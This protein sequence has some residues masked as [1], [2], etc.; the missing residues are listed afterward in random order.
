MFFRYISS[1]HFENGY[2]NKSLLV[3]L[4]FIRDNMV[5]MNRPYSSVVI[6]DVQKNR[7]CALYFLGYR[8][9]GFSN[10]L[11]FRWH[12]FIMRIINVSCMP[13]PY[14][15]TFYNM[16]GSIDKNSGGG[17]GARHFTMC[18]K[19]VIIFGLQICACM[20]LLL[21]LF[22]INSMHLHVYTIS[23]H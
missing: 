8:M 14:Y 19:L 21:P 2:L 18:I 3:C 23:T 16:R 17:G 13:M 22:A 9:R 20:T 11:L 4:F 6:I 1:L 5:T 7:R 15:C 10:F 12:I